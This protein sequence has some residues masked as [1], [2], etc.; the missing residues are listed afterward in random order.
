MKN[1]FGS[2]IIFASDGKPKIK[3]RENEKRTADEIPTVGTAAQILHEVLPD[4]TSFSVHKEKDGF[5]V[6]KI[7]GKV[8][9]ITRP[10]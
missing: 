10:A 6:A 5:P 8:P 9:K 2:G 1:Q 3:N 7:P 4:G